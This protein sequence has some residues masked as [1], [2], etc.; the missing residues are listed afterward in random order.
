MVLLNIFVKSAHVTLNIIFFCS[1]EPEG[2]SKICTLKCPIIVISSLDRQYLYEFTQLFP[3]KLV[4]F[5]LLL[6]TEIRPLG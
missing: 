4:H 5:R 6:I 2:Y 3:I 1:F